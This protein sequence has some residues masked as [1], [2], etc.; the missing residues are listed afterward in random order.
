V[1]G[2]KKPGNSAM[3]RVTVQTRDML[4]V[5]AAEKGSSMQGVAEEAVEAY[6]RQMILDQTSAAYDRLCD[7]PEAAAAL[8]AEE[9]DWDATLC[10]GLEDE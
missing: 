5:I 6:R 9:R 2:T 8:E 3:L 4:S 1:A 7:D 10:D